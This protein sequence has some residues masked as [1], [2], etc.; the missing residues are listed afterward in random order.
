MK[1]ASVYVMA[2]VT[3]VLVGGAALAE[4]EAEYLHP[5]V[6]RKSTSPFGPA[7]PQP[8]APKPRA[9]NAPMFAPAAAASSKRMS[10]QQ[11][12]EWRFL[13]E[14]SAVGRFEAEASRL[15]LAKSTHQGI[16]SLAAALVSHH[17]SVSNELV[18]MLH[19]RGM[20]PPM[21]ANDQR[22]TLN[23]LAKLQGRKFDREF[24]EEVGLKS[25]QEHV[26][27]FERGRLAVSDPQIKAWIERILPTLRNQLTMA[28]RLAPADPK[29]LRGAPAAN[30]EP[31]RRAHR[32]G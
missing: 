26:Q 6:P 8:I 13:K 14:A 1:C 9:A 32:S 16:R 12:E 2:V 18:H 25:Q 31:N 22:K 20:A 3:A 24:M 7:T 15:A 23:R 17:T 19:V 10:E 11:R 29:L 5:G 28:E 21:L 30:A 27:L 4:T